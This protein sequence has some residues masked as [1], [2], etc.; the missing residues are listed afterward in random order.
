M[1]GESGCGKSTIAR[2]IMKLTPSTGGKILLNG[3]DITKLNNHEMYPLRRDMSMVFQDPYGSLD[4]R[5]R[6]VDIVMEPLKNFYPNMS[7]KEMN[8]RVEELFRLVGLDPAY[9]ERVPHEF[10]GGQRQRLAIARAISTNP[11]FIICDEAISALDVSIQ[12]QIIN[13]LEDLQE[14]LEITYLFIA[15]DLSVVR[16]ISD[17]VAV[18]YLGQLVEVADWDK[19]Y[20]NP[21]HPYTKALLEAVPEAD[22][23][24]EQT[25]QRKI[26]TGEIPSPVNR[27]K[28]CAFSTR[29][30]LATEECRNIPPE[31]LEKQDRH[32]VACFKV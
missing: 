18:M 15:H 14:Q 22:P 11:Q 29:C 3:T 26:I 10:S 5:Q 7:K 13:L 6:A 17:R 8:D 25:T 31:L 1:V 19:L 21:L 27:P 30:P 12:A 9:K 28:G 4:P 20:D 2:T 23:I 24:L 16:H 32:M